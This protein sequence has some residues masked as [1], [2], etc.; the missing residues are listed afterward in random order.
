MATTPDPMCCPARRA[1]PPHPLAAAVGGGGGDRGGDAAAGADLGAAHRP[2]STRP[3]R[4]P[5]PARCPPVRARTPAAADACA[6]ELIRT[7]VGWTAAQRSSDLRRQSLREAARRCS[8][9]QPGLVES[10]LLRLDDG[11][12]VL[13]LLGDTDDLATPD[14]L[15]QAGPP[16]AR[17]GVV[18]LNAPS[19]LFLDRLH[20][21]PGT[22]PPL[23]LV[24]R[25]LPG[26]G[27]AS[28]SAQPPLASD[29]HDEVPT[30]VRHVQWLLSALAVG[31]V[32]L[33]MASLRWLGRTQRDYQH[34]LRQEIAARQGTALAL[35]S[36][37][38][39][40]EDIEESIGV[41]LRVVNAEGRLTYVNR[42]FC[43]TSGWSREALIGVLPPYP[44]WPGAPG[45]AARR[46]P[47]R[48]PRRPV[49]AGRFPRAL[50][51]P[52][53][54][55]LDRPGQRPRTRQRRG[56]D[57]RQHRHH[58]RTRRPAPHRGHERRVAPA[59]L[60]LPAR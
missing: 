44:F 48:H 52:G 60:G 14:Y 16:L 4:S 50:H 30:A 40:R 57:P 31:L 8:S 47:A 22:Q 23:A 25:Y 32:G 13:G 20:P 29:A 38:A 34:T 27:A 10:H 49:A 17:G 45:R 35:Q 9:G 6:R 56:L 42:A 24:Q 11:T 36:E 51:A 3:A 41:G 21:V 5:P 18:E 28:A 2:G 46:T 59:V 12:L 15:A 37:I 19:G 54:H 26:G 55:P 7:W 1:A 43:D 39:F 33:V 53:R 58:P